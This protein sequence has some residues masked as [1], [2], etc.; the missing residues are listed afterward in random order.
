MRKITGRSLVGEQ[1]GDVVVGEVS[2][3]ELIHDLVSLVAGGGDAE[4]RFL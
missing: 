2:G 3:F 4:Y 1:N